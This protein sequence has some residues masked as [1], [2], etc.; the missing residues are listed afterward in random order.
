MCFAKN[1]PSQN[2]SHK[3]SGWYQIKLNEIYSKGYEEVRTTET[4]KLT[5]YRAVLKEVA[6]EV[7]DGFIEVGDMSQTLD[8]RFKRTQGGQTFWVLLTL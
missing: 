1:K 6:R 8:V 2:K 4:L 7:V 5:N 3:I